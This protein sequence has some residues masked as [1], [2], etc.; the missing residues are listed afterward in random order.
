[1]FLFFMFLIYRLRVILSR[2]I[3]PILE[4]DENIFVLFHHLAENL[5]AESLPFFFGDFASVEFSKHFIVAFD[6]F[7]LHVF[8]VSREAC[9][10]K[11]YF[12]FF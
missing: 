7:V 3:L 10:R 11:D 8:K 1:M 2:I 4:A 5:K 6:R 12:D 9:E